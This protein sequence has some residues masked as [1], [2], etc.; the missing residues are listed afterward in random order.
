[1]RYINYVLIAVTSALCATY[2]VLWLIKPSPLESTT[3][4]GE[5]KVIGTEHMSAKI[6]RDQVIRVNECQM[7]NPRTRQL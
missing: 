2:S 3:G 5:T 1:M 6:C 4:L 7:T